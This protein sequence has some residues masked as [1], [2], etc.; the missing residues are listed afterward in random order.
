MDTELSAAK[1]RLV[2][3][4]KR[5]G[6]RTAAE[7]AAEL[8]TTPT[9]VRQHLSELAD[10]DLVTPASRPPEGRGRPAT[11]WSRI[12]EWSSAINGS[13]SSWRFLAQWRDS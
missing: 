3:L 4:L 1:R 5:R 13:W 11:V 10:A 2:E 12:G 8:G 6:G 7:L 9:A